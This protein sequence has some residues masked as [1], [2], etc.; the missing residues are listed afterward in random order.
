MKKMIISM[1]I[2]ATEEDLNDIK[3]SI[4]TRASDALVSVSTNVIEEPRKEIDCGMLA[5][6]NNR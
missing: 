1:V 4:I 3:A 2:E 6:I 5:F